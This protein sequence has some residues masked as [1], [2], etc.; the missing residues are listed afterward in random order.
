MEKNIFLIII[1]NT[2]DN[3]SVEIKKREVLNG[4]DV[5]QNKPLSSNL[6]YL[7]VSSSTNWKLQHQRNGAQVLGKIKYTDETIK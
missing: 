7:S 3:F 2:Q 4:V 5:R 1:R 6:R